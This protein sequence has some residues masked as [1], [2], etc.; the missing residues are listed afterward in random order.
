MERAMRRTQH[1]AAK[2]VAMIALSSVCFGQ[3]PPPYPQQTQSYPPPQQRFPQQ[4][5][6]QQQ[7]QP[8]QED[9]DAANHSAARISVMSGDVSVRRGDNGDFV[10]AVINAPLVMGDRILTG[11]DGRAEVQFDSSNMIRVA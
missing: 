9:P 1:L 10:A 3:Y 4:G 5:P 11:P 2:M 6:P 7:Q 8:Q